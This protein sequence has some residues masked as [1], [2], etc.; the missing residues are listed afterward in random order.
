MKI[1]QKGRKNESGNN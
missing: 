1:V